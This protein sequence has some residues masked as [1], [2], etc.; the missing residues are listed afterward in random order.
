MYDNFDLLEL[1]LNS[2]RQL[3]VAKKFL[4]SC[5]LQY[6]V[7]DR[8]YGIFDADKLI[9]TG[10]FCANVIKCVAVEELYREYGLVNR[11]ISR[12]RS[13]MS[14]ICKDNIFIF[15]KRKYDKIFADLS[16]YPIAYSQEA[17]LLESKRNGVSDFCKKLAKTAVEGVNGVVVVNCNPITNGH[18]Y[19]LEQASKEVDRLH[20][21]VVGEDGQFLKAAERLELVQR[22]TANLPK[23]VVHSAEKYCV[24]RAT[25]PSYFLKDSGVVDSNQMEMDLDL[26][27][28]YIAPS[29]RVSVRFV[30]SEPTD[31]VT[32]AYNSKMQEI[33]PRYG[34]EV[35][36]I[37]RLEYCGKAIS[38]S[39]VRKL[40][41]K[42]DL[43]GIKPL[44][45][46]CVFD[47][48]SAKA[49]GK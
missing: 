31:M 47:F 26:F 9:A 48:L 8:L 27:V 7:L 14:N 42:G 11:I 30:G 37:D 44:V 28:R 4:D 36:V 25:F 43:V 10:G 40:Y 3:N 17:V 12:L 33:L 16:F 41:D 24:S 22:A 35:K 20:I 6:E 19:L 13:E 15:T 18:L 46:Q 5:G 2:K 34:I 38:A 21:L 23:A 39:T 29:M 45:P 32:S 1:D 49:T